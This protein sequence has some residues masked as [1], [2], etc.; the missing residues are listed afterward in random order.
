MISPNAGDRGERLRARAALTYWRKGLASQN[1]GD[2][3]SEL[4]FVALSRGPA[5]GGSRDERAVGRPLH[6]FGQL[7][8]IGSVISQWHI[9]T[10]LAA[11]ADDPQ[12]RV[13]FWCC[14]MREETPPDPELAARC[15]FMGVRGPLTRDGLGLSLETT[16]GDPGLL[17]P[18][19][20][21]PRPAPLYRGRA[22]CMP[23]FLE[24]MSDAALIAMTDAEVVVRPNIPP[25]RAAALAVIDA[26]AA[27][28]FL[29]TGAL[30]G[31]VIAAA[32]GVPFAYF[33]SG[34]IDAPLK[35]RDFAA[36]VHM[37]PTFATTVETGRRLYRAEIRPALRLPS[38]AA[39]L[40]CAP[41]AAPAALVR[42]ARAF[43]AAQI[44]S[45]GA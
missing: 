5:R 11:L 6:D 25:S 31:A 40:A 24:P 17:V 36:L 39:I 9:S 13:G 45:P 34:Y 33:D 12:A 44:S 35:W 3:L 21:R 28:D 20:H 30:H 43:D 27:A 23:H 1:L 8:M 22:V 14:G 32:Y 41:L 38:L 2:Y 29:L 18:L 26:I 4:L 7:F 37:P 19:I 16:L 10:A 42:R 15:S